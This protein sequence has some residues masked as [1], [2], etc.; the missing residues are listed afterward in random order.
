MEGY[1]SFEEYVEDTIAHNGI[2][3]IFQSCFMIVIKRNLS[4]QCFVEC[5]KGDCS[6]F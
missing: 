2:F 1:L 3:T 5:I 6:A 4:A